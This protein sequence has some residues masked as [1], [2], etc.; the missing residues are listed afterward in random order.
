MSYR[1]QSD[2]DLAQFAAI[3]AQT[4]ADHK[5]KC[6]PDPV[7][8]AY[9]A[10][11]APISDAF[12]D[13]IQESVETTNKLRG[14]N[15][16]KNDRREQVVDVVAEIYKMIRANRDHTDVDLDICGFNS[17]RKWTRVVAKVPSKLAVT[18]IGN[19]LN[20]I[21]F[22]GNNARNSVGYEIWRREGKDG[23]W[24]LLITIRKQ[25][26]IDKLERPGRFYAYKVR[27][28]A[29]STVSAFSNIGAVNTHART[30]KEPEAGA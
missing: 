18:D 7:A 21:K 28:V 6:L 9:A 10:E 29:S 15:A 17:P 14:I 5:V 25:S 22:A 30:Q 3:L 19:G 11:L 8:D 16:R 1:R 2:S 4:L 26:H 12:G 23:E 24:T 13:D 20:K 27:A